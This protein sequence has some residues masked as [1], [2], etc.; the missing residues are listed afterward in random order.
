MALLE[1]FESNIKKVVE[2]LEDWQQVIEEQL[3][4]EDLGTSTMAN[5]VHKTVLSKGL[6]KNALNEVSLSV[7]CGS[8]LWGDAFTEILMWLSGYMPQYKTDIEQQ[9][10]N[11]INQLNATLQA[12]DSLK[13]VLLL[14]LSSRVG[15][16][17][18]KL[19]WCAKKAREEEEGRTEAKGNGGQGGMTTGRTAT[20]TKQKPP[21]EQWKPPRGYT[22]AKAIVAMGVPR[23][24]LEGWVQRHTPDKVKKDPQTQECYYPNKWLKERVKNYKPRRKG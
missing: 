15:K 23:S 18:H 11:I 2:V 14:G 17:K 22:G 7:F 24:T 6:K 13:E 1:E 9:Y 5:V 20:K 19:C 12:D 21:P 10:S 8:A 4:S 3:I 16:L